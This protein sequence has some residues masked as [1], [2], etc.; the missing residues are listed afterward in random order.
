ML[1]LASSRPDV[2]KE[3]PAGW[4]GSTQVEIDERG[5]AVVPRFPAGDL[6]IRIMT[7]GFVSERRFRSGDGPAATLETGALGAGKTLQLRL[8]VEPE[9]R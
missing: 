5:R 9:S 4:L 8:T 6:S 7:P 2:S 1:C 3:D